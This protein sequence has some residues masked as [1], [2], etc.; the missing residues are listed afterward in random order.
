MDGQRRPRRTFLAGMAGMAAD[1]DGKDPGG[2][3]R[4]A[5][6]PV[7]VLAVLLAALLPT[8]L[9]PVPE[10]G[11]T[12]YTLAVIVSC[13]ACIAF[14]AVAWLDRWMRLPE[15]VRRGL[16]MA[17]LA[18]AAVIGCTQAVLLDRSWPG[19]TVMTVALGAGLLRLRGS[20]FAGLVATSTAL[21]F[22]TA[23]YALAT[24]AP[25]DGWLQVSAGVA[26]GGVLALAARTGRLRA[27]A[28]VDAAEESAL[29]VEVHDPATG[30]LN[31]RGLEIVAIPMIENARR[32]GGAVSAL[33]VDIDGLGR[34]NTTLG[35]AG[36]DL[37]IQ[38]VADGLRS[39]VRSTDV[40]C[41]RGGDEF[42][43]IG[44]GTGMSPLELE[45]RIR[46]AL[47]AEPPVDS[48]V[49]SP[50]ISAGSATLVP[51]DEGDL[52]ALIHRA[53]QDLDLR[54]SLRRSPVFPAGTA[55]RDDEH[56]V[57]GSGT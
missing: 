34:V 49:W 32:Q 37:V 54:R 25:T 31:P 17:L 10:H 30:A 46:A 27:Q 56:P 55:Q 33:F 42:V 1:S 21:W 44:P 23:G 2:D 9:S 14:L 7:A 4:V 35:L 13:A 15:R 29:S 20:A 39:C 38:A 16:G 5:A 41:R 57:A 51:W 8:A 40:V 52:G 50:R 12:Q 24:G 45:R 53:E 22:V 6:A 36:G 3:S 47:G 48:S 19:V 43:I 28:M 26:V 18:S 11:G